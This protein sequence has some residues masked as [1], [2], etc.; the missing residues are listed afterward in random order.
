MEEVRNLNLWVLIERDP[1]IEGRWVAHCVDLDIVSWGDSP[2]AARQA[3]E[4]A[5]TLA[6]LDDLHAGLDPLERG[7]AP[8]NVRKRLEE[9]RKVGKPVDISQPDVAEREHVSR[10]ATL[11][12]LRFVRAD[13]L[14][15]RDTTFAMDAA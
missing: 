7:P 13:L 9:L 8:E 15:G 2:A 4:E 12:Q 1:D 6:I 10:F 5:V 11:L 3:I 14:E